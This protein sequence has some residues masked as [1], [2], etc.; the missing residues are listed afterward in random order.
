MRL[1]VISYLSILAGAAALLTL[2]GCSTSSRYYGND[3]PPAV[4]TGTGA[5]SAVTKV[6]PFRAAANRPYTCSDPPIRQ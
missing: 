3:G 2:S 6:E 4:F 5:E 1:P